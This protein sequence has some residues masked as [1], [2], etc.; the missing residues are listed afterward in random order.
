MTAESPN[1]QTYELNDV[2]VQVGARLTIN[3]SLVLSG[4]ASF[5][6]RDGNAGYVA[7]HNGFGRWSDQ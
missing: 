3:F 1:F 2:N 5:C 6:R 4:A 7:L